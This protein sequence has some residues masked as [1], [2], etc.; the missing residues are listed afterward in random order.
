MS[1]ENKTDSKKP[2]PNA[3]ERINA[4][5]RKKRLL[6]ASAAL[7]FLHLGALMLASVMANSFAVWACVV[8]SVVFL[9]LLCV[10]NK[11]TA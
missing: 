1:S 4:A 6:Y 5:R 10:L 7:L 3:Q 9:V 2:M 8:A 11:E